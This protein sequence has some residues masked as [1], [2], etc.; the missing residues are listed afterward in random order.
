MSNARL[1]PDSFVGGGDGTQISFRDILILLC[2][3]LPLADDVAFRR[4]AKKQLHAAWR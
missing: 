3:V 4:W 2:D 1:A